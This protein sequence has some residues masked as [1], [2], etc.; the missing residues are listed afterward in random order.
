MRRA[1]FD[2]ALANTPTR[3]LPLI[4]IG[5]VGEFV[6]EFPKPEIL[7]VG[8]DAAFVGE[9]LQ[10][11]PDS[12]FFSHLMQLIKAHVVGRLFVLDGDRAVGTV[13][14]GCLSPTLDVSIAMAIV[15]R[16][17]TDEGRALT[18]DLGRATDEAVV[19]PLPF[20]TRS[21]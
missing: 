21:K 16:D 8:R 9:A 7:I 11:R 5:F 14:S 1:F 2:L 19:T 4:I 10:A 20:Y 6:R 15:D 13:T 18:V 3:T 17:V 12:I